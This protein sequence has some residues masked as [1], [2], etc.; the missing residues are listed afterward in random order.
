MSD[1]N[2]DPSITAVANRAVSVAGTSNARDLLKVSRIGPSLEQSENANLEITVNARAEDLAPTATANELKNLG[3]AIGNLLEADTFITGKFI[4]VQ[5]FNSGKFLGTNSATESWGGVEIAKIED[6]EISSVSTGESLVYNSVSGKFENSSD[7][8]SVQSFATTAEIDAVT[9]VP[10]DVGFDSETSELKY[11]DGS[12]WK[13]A[14]V[15]AAGGGGGGASFDWSVIDYGLTAHTLGVH[16][17]SYDYFGQSLGSDDNVIGVS[18][19]RYDN[20]GNLDYA[21]GAIRFYTH[22]FTYAGEITNSTDSRDSYGTSGLTGT[23][24]WQWAGHQWLSVHNGRAAFVSKQLSG[25]AGAHNRIVDV[26]DLNFDGTNINPTFVNM[27]HSADFNSDGK[28]GSNWGMIGDL[29]GNY[30]ILGDNGWDGSKGKVFVFDVT[31]GSIADPTPSLLYTIDQTQSGANNNNPNNASMFGSAI[32]IADNGTFAVS[33]PYDTQNTVPGWYGGSVMIFNISD[34]SLVTTIDVSHYGLPDFGNDKATPRAPANEQKELAISDDGSRIVVGDNSIG[35]SGSYS[36]K[37]CVAVYDVSTGNR[38]YVQRPYE[39]G[40]TETNSRFGQKVDISPD[41][42]HI[43][44]SA[45]DNHA[46]GGN[47]DLGSIW[48]ADI[49]NNTVQERGPTQHASGSDFGDATAFGTHVHFTKN[50]VLAS[51]ET[52][53]KVWYY[54]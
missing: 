22:D 33:A 14:A 26:W 16:E 43:V 48:I 40:V 44:W 45:Y 52:K 17:P 46:P 21:K 38:I 35:Y 27:Y 8:F 51:S 49:D 29:R 19:P 41:G 54:G 7:V 37:G 10:G 25:S 31:Q 53:D 18:A 39:V 13:V 3:S 50:K 15:V 24:T 23:S 6:V 4:P 36:Q 2:L 11:W 47:S 12:E 30:L 32:A 20:P 42:T 9:G 5:Q 28:N 1:T 34:G